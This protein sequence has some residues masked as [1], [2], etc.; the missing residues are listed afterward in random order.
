MYRYKKEAFNMSIYLAA[1]LSMK[2][3]QYC[4]IFSYFPVIS[5]T[6]DKLSKHVTLG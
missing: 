1:Q 2:Q 3:I 6:F 4:W 5:K